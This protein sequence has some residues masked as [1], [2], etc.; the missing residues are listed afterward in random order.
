M[1][2]NFYNIQLKTYDMINDEIDKIMQSITNLIED[3][4]TPKEP[5]SLETQE[6]KSALILIK[7]LHLCILRY[8]YRIDYARHNHDY[9]D[10]NIKN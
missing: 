10:K 3:T 5:N 9:F 7:E 6:I 8:S 1:I 2:L 4:Q